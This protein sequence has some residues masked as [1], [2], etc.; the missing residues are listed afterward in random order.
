MPL[1]SPC[2]GSRASQGHRVLSCRLSW[3]THPSLSQKGC[4]HHWGTASVPLHGQN[5]EQMFSSKH[6]EDKSK[7]LGF[8]SNNHLHLLSIYYV[9]HLAPSHL[10]H[11]S[12]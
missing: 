5:S 7:C 3:V 1:N 6:L 12:L 8:L 4:P 11:T 2:P 9:L 10:S